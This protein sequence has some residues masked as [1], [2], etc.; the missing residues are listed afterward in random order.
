M[1]SASA[2]LGLEQLAFCSVRVRARLRS[3]V[4]LLSTQSSLL[5]TAPKVLSFGTRE[6]QQLWAVEHF[7]APLPLFVDTS[8]CRVSASTLESTPSSE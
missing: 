1:L 6:H 7:A 5:A 2:R 4:V 8:S 3:R